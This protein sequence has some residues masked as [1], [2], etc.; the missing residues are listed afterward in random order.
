MHTQNEAP[1]TSRCSWPLWLLAIAVIFVGIPMAVA[2]HDPMRPFR[3]LVI[4]IVIS[5]WLIAM[6]RRERSKGWIFYIVLL[7]AVEFCIGPIAELF[8]R[9]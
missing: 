8:A 3:F 4:G 2:V 5:R 9:K 7:I 6:L 1:K